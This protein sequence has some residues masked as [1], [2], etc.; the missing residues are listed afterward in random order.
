MLVTF[1]SLFDAD[2]GLVVYDLETGNRTF[3]S[4]RALNGA[5][6]GH[7]VKWLAGKIE[8]SLTDRGGVSR[9]FLVERTSAGKWRASFPDGRPTRIPQL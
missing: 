5:F 1:P 4:D 3:A 6:V 8:L 2:E 9:R 7:E